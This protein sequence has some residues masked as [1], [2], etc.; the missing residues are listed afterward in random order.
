M[1]WPGSSISPSGLKLLVDDVLLNERE[2]VVE[3]GSGISTVALGSAVA[4]VG[5][6]M[7]SFEEN[8]EWK[9]M[10]DGWL[11]EAGIASSVQVIHAPTKATSINGYEGTWYD[12]SVVLGHIKGKTIAQLLVDGPTACTVGR[13][14]S[15]YPA[16][17]VLFESFG[18]SF[19]VFLD[20]SD[21]LGEQRIVDRWERETGWVFNRL[22][23]VGPIAYTV[24]GGGFFFGA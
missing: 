16:V 15:R 13:E 10:V 19:S 5:G 9:G 20:D 17:P 1:P 7:L 4:Q 22:S 23:D 12:K 21:R 18:K 6:K 3:M 11:S 8:A 2:L 24:Q 14:M